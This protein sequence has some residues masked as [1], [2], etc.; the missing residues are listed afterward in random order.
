MNE[1]K[2]LVITAHPDDAEI[3]CYGTIAKHHAAGYDCLVVVCSDGKNGGKADRK[4]ESKNA[5]SKLKIN[6]KYLD[7][8]DGKI[9]FDIDLI[10][11]IR[12]IIETYNPNIVITHYPEAKGFEH[13]DH[14]AIAKAVINAVS[15][16]QSNIRLVLLAEPMIT[17]MTDFKPNYFID[18]TEWEKEKKKALKKHISQSKKYYM[19]SQYVDLRLKAYSMSVPEK[20]LKKTYEVFEMLFQIK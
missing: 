10:S 20:S 9:Q 17:G 11:E 18:I 3:M 2:L 14:T 19:T 4:K 7:F 16:I 5:L 1:Q 8:E 6:T 12:R 13:Q 15:K